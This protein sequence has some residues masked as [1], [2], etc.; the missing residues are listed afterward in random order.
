MQSVILYALVAWL[1]VRR[2]K[3]SIGFQKYNPTTLIMRM[4]AFGIIALSIL[5][6][7]IIFPS[8]LWYEGLG[9]I[10]GL[11]L[12]YIATNHAEFEKRENVLYF[13]THV[14][15][16]I[17]V[18]CLFLARFIYR[19]VIT[20]DMF[21]PGEDQQDLQTKIHTMHDPITGF[22]LFTFCAYYIGYYSFILKEGKKV[23]KTDSGAT[24]NLK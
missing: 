19:I 13:K 1:L 7:S 5:C 16:E 21:Q 15:I 14:W 12:A 11:V 8:V 6:T 20:K 23:M 2:I 10:A 3:R 18:I 4:V 9:I 24:P 17:I 22:I